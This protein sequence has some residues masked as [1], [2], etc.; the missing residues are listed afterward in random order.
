MAEAHLVG[1]EALKP[2]PSLAALEWLLGTWTT[3]G[4]HPLV[5]GKIFHGRA[6]FEWHEGGAFLAV[7]TDMEETEIPSSVALI[8]SDDGEERLF[9]LY[10]DARGVSRHMEVTAGDG[11]VVWRRD[12]PAFRQSWTLTRVSN[13][14]LAGRGRMSKDGGDWEDDLS[15]DYVRVTERSEV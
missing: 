6:V 8:G 2:N 7:R 11:F 3:T 12:F 9:M 13:D 1:R 10:F 5:P 14:K 4:K 15:L